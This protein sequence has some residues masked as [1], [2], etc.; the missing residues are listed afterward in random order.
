MTEPIPVTEITAKEISDWLKMPVTKLLALALRGTYLE[1]M[2][3]LNTAP[4][5]ES[6]LAFRGRI[7]AV[8][9]I[10][11]LPAWMHQARLVAISQSSPLRQQQLMALEVQIAQET[12]SYELEEEPMDEPEKED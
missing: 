3:E 1:M 2:A 11:Y 6:A 8:K 4:D 12:E 7:A 9:D 10:M 5:W